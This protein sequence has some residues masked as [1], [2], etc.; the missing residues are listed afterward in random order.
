MGTTSNNALGIGA[1]DVPAMSRTVHVLLE[2]PYGSLAMNLWNDKYPIVVLIAG[3]IGV[4][5]ISSLTRQLLHEHQHE[6][7][8]NSPCSM[9]C[10]RLVFGGSTLLGQQQQDELEECERFWKIRGIATVVMVWFESIQ[11]RALVIGKEV[12]WPTMFET[13]PIRLRSLKLPST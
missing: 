11:L 12:S 2:G 5:P 4:T 3:G 13:A 1:A 10:S 8:E 9:G 6:R 7:T